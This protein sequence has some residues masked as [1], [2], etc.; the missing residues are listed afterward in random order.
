MAPFRPFLAPSEKAQAPRLAGAAAALL[1]MAV[2]GVLFCLVLL[3]VEDKWSPLLQVDDHLRDSVHSYAL[4]HP[5]FVTWMRWISNS[6]SGLAWQIVT[7]TLAAWLLWKR[8]IRL[9]LFVV[10][11]IALSSLLN[12]V[13]KAGVHRA[14]PVL[15]EPLVHEPGMSFPSGHSQ[16]AVVGYSVVMIVV[17]PLLPPAG[18]RALAAVCAVMV[19]LI[20][21]SRIALGAHYLTDVVAGFLLGFVWVAVMA[22][23]F[24]LRR[25]PWRSAV[26]GEQVGAAAGTTTA[27][28]S[29]RP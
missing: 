24:D 16:A 10:V 2:L 7:V 20:G 8:R 1:V 25:H 15:S 18:R 28:K 17:A 6:G 13:V 26:R 27:G 3:L 22:T 23:I 11:T 21:F 29:Y 12:S 19:L 9:A 5:T 14:R 4:A